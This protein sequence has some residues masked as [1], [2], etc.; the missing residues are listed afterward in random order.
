[1]V[2][3]AGYNPGLVVVDLMALHASYKPGSATTTANSTSNEDFSGPNSRKSIE[4]RELRSQHEAECRPLL[5]E[6]R[7]DKHAADQRIRLDLREKGNKDDHLLN[8]EQELLLDTHEHG[9]KCGRARTKVACLI[10]IFCTTFE[11]RPMQIIDD[12]AA[13][14]IHIMYIFYDKE[15]HGL[16]LD[17]SI[18]QLADNDGSSLIPSAILRH[19]NSK[20]CRA[21]SGYIGSSFSIRF[22]T[23]HDG[24]GLARVETVSNGVQ[25]N[26]E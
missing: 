11:I 3:H 4:L 9:H 20:A 6:L 17:K 16:L 23:K 21:G 19:L 1:N 2:P 25:D 24:C 13:C 15:S 5:E 12:N 18:Y 22:E 10:L 7:I 14:V 8:A 26:D